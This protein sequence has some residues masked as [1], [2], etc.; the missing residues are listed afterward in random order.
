MRSAGVAE[1]RQAIEDAVHGN[2]G[3]SNRKLFGM[4]YT[5]TRKT[6]SDKICI[7]DD[8]FFRARNRE[9]HDDAILIAALI[10]VDD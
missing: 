9:C 5:R 2:L 7:F 4:G 1:L 6:A 8:E 10:A 3:K